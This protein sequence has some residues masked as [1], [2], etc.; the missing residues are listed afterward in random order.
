MKKYRV[1]LKDSSPIAKD[2]KRL[3]KKYPSVKEDLIPAFQELEEDPAKAADSRVPRFKGDVWKKWIKSSD[4][5]KGKQKGFRLI[6][7]WKLKTLHVFPIRLYSKS[8][9]DELTQREI[10]R[11]M[12]Q[13]ELE[14]ST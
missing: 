8:E 13:T 14:E 5:K 11:A 1:V 7:Y 6:Y 2:I 10:S 4:L 3:S 9:T 12:K